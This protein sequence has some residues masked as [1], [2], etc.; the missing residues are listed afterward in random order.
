MVD[1]P[2]RGRQHGASARIRL[3]T[4]MAVLLV[5]V[6]AG[7]TVALGALTDTS[8]ALAAAAARHASAVSP[9]GHRS[10]AGS[11]ATTAAPT[12]TTSAVAPATTVPS[13]VPSTVP[14]TVPSTAAGTVPAAAPSVT[15]TSNP[16]APVTTD[17]PALVARVEASGIAPGPTWTWSYGDTSACGAIPGTNIG[18]GC[19]SGAAGAVTTV[20]AGAPGLL[21]V[22]HELANAETE[23]YAVPN[24]VALV[25]RSAGGTSWSAI[26]AVASCLVV[27]FLGVQ[28]GAAG[29]WACP[30]ALAD[31]V[32]AGIHDAGF[33]A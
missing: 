10:T 6:T 13:T 8:P 5:L 7:A 22:A 3:M 29:T 18:T 25:A 23:N 1:L 4:A 17:V 31:V 33:S 12:T 28:D 21:L 24:L 26:D 9:T 2:T 30:T 16:P 14:T 15:T 32:A 11:V 27:H 20:F 19:T